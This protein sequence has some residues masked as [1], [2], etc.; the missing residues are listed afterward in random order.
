[1]ASEVRQKV[2]TQSAS[3]IGPLGIEAALA[4][5]ASPSVQPRPKIFDELALTDRVALVS[6]GNRGLGLDMA[7]AL[8]EAGARV[9]YCFDLPEKPSE[10]RTGPTTAMEESGGDRR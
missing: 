1:M 3:P 7:I 10:V 6:G 4:A 2:K 9:V 5:E 8:C